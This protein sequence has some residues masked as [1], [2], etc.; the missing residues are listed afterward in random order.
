MTNPTFRLLDTRI[1][2]G[3]FILL[4]A[5][6]HRSCGQIEADTNPQATAISSTGAP[7]AAGD[8]DA[9]PT[10]TAH[11]LTRN[12]RDFGAKGDGA[13]LDTASVNRAI[14]ECNRAGGGT[15]F[16]PAGIYKVGTVTMLSN[17]TLFLDAG[18]VIRGSGDMHDYPVIPYTS[19]DRNTTLFFAKGGTRHRH[20][21]ARDDRWEWRRFRVLRPGGQGKGFSG[22]IH[23]PG[24]PL[25][26]HQ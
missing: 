17:V 14:V 5:L 16:F 11:G 12:V 20:H 26:R 24:R 18:S 19:E 1:L 6:P 22:F 8:T 15:V 21:G 3:A 4:L 7:R 13:A 25:L 9:A 2:G 10:Q 23:A